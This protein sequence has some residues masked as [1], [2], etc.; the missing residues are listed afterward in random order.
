MSAQ[1]ERSVTRERLIATL[2]TTLGLLSLSLAAIG[3]YGLL[4]YWVARRTQEIGVRL[5]LGAPRSSVL[6]LVLNDALRTITIG[7]VIG[8]PIAWIL[9]RFIRSLLFGLQPTDLPTIVGAITVLAATGLVAAW[10]P[11]RRAMRVNPVV[12]LRYE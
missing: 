2:A 12:A 10:I 11:G 8:V 1:L 7:V 6:A 5:A 3:L 9:G 4:A